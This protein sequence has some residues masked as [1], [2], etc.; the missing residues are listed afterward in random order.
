MFIKYD[1]QTIFS[2]VCCLSKKEEEKSRK[3]QCQKHFVPE[4]AVGER[5]GGSVEGGAWSIAL[6]FLKLGSHGYTNCV[7]KIN[8]HNKEI[9]YLR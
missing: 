1:K 9:T 5:G 6:K 4:E 7:L 8:Q 3:S 2:V